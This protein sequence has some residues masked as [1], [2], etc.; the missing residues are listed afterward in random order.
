M[1][2]RDARIPPDLPRLSLLGLLL[3]NFWFPRYRVAGSLRHRHIKD[4][5]QDEESGVD[6]SGNTTRRRGARIHV[7]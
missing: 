6:P 3:L 4:R 7:R 1:N 5:R 2:T